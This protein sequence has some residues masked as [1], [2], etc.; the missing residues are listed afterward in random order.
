MSDKINKLEF[1]YDIIRQGDNMTNYKELNLIS[2]SYFEGNKYNI[3]LLSNVSA[4]LNQYI[5]DINWI[6]F[7]IFKDNKLILGP[8]KGKIACTEIEMNS[9]VCGTAAFLKET[10]IVED[11]HKF[12][13]H[14]ACDSASNSEIVVPI[15]IVGKLYGVLDVDSTSFGRFSD[16]DK[17]GLEEFVE[18]I[19]KNIML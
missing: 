6:G 16:S 2:K 7:Y 11:V 5:D 4:L 9:G 19:K 13:G 1:L 18:N 15:V 10:L 3:T 17:D 8:F 14:I 12:K